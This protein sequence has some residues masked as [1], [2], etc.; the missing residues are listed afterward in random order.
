LESRLE[1]VGIVAA[2][3]RG[4]QEQ[5]LSRLAD[6]DRRAH[7]HGDAIVQLQVHSLMSAGVS[8]PCDPE[9]RATLVASTGLRGAN[10]DWLATG[11]RMHPASALAASEPGKK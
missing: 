9:V 1:Q 11:P 4:E 10:L 2:L 8:G 5:A 6:L 3:A 7:R